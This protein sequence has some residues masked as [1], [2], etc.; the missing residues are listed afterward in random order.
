MVRGIENGLAF[1]IDSSICGFGSF[2]FN[3]I[4]S[5]FKFA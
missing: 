5:L 4:V 1:N 2:I 3:G